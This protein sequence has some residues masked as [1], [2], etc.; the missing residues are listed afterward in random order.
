MNLVIKN[1]DDL[2]NYNLMK[3]LTKSHKFVYNLEN[4]S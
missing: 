3:D 2:V 4:L 1:L